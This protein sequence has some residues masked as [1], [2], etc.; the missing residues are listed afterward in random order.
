MSRYSIIIVIIIIFSVN[1]IE[2]R[3]GFAPDM[4][5]QVKQIKNHCTRHAANVSNI[6]NNNNVT[7]NCSSDC[8]S[9]Y[10]TYHKYCEYT[11]KNFIEKCITN[12][13]SLNEFIIIR[14]NCIDKNMNELS[15]SIGIAYLLIFTVILCFAFS[16]KK[17][18]RY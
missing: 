10:T 14:T 2:S 12:M 9:Y 3:R 18:N 13:T 16:S 1:L 17:D 5:K 8:Y 15:S 7:E 4:R 6:I 11:N